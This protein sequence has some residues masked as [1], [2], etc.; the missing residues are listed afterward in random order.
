MKTLEKIVNSIKKAGRAIR[1]NGF[2]IATAIA[3]P[4]VFNSSIQAGEIKIMNNT[5][6]PSVDVSNMYVKYIP[7]A[8]EGDDYADNS[9]FPPYIEPWLKVHS[10]PYGT[11]LETDARPLNT[12]QVEFYLSVVGNIKGKINNKVKFRVTDPNN[13]EYRDVIAYSTADPN[14]VHNIPKDGTLYTVTLDNLVNPSPEVYATWHIATPP[15]VPGDC[16]SA[17]GAGILDG[18]KNIYDTKVVCE[19]WLT[20]TFEGEN[21]SLGDLNYDGVD[22]FQDFALAAENNSH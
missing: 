10:E 14:T 22:D 19:R 5:T 1:K 18:V 20:E 17:A 13:L 16:G 21:Y 4:F 7:D 8:N 9:T 6:D 3:L 11:E 12:P 15:I 2:R